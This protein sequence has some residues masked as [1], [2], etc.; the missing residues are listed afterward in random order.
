MAHISSDPDFKMA[1][2]ARDFH[3]ASERV[4]DTFKI[5]SLY[6]EQKEYLEAL[7]TGKDVYASLP[8]GY[9]KSLIFFAVPI[10]AD[11]LFS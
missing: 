1:V 7:F 6:N 9:G 3:R 5:P 11:E 4:C 8:T 10:I 2:N